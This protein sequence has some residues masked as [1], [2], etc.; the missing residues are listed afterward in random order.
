MLTCKLAN[1]LCVRIAFKSH[2]PVFQI[3]VE[4]ARGWSWPLT[5]DRSREQYWP[6]V[7]TIAV[8]GP[9]MLVDHFFRVLALLRKTFICCAVS[10]AGLPV[11]WDLRSIWV[12][13]LGWLLIRQVLL[14][15]MV[16][17]PLWPVRFLFSIQILWYSHRRSPFP[18]GIYGYVCT[19]TR[20]NS[21]EIVHWINSTWS[22]FLRGEKKSRSWS[23]LLSG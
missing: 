3:Y 9:S 12:R 6:C 14:S 11:A 20:W 2:L 8:L 5:Q 10:V 19:C 15:E 1:D 18:C 17:S 4:K 22:A 16:Y 7:A 21:K 23:G 13:M